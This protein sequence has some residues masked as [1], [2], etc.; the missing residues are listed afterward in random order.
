MDSIKLF[1]EDF[2]ALIYPKHCYGCEGSLSAGEN[3]LCTSCLLQIPESLRTEDVQ[4]MQLKF[5]GISPIGESF[6]LMKFNKSGIA[7]KMMHSIKY[8][9]NQ[10]LAVMLGRLLGKKIIENIPEKPDALVP[11]PLHEKKQRRRGFNQSE[12]I[13]HGVSEILEVPVYSLLERHV[14]NPTQ[15]RKSKLERWRNTSDIFRMNEHLDELPRR[16]MLI[17]DTL[18][19]GATISAASKVLLANSVDEIDLAVLALAQ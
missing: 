1:A 10:E 18:T 9:G 15:T 2:L 12:Q 14:D 5:A 13:A 4:Q 16:I 11:I 8:E 19:T 3:L 6:S 17:D 7:Q